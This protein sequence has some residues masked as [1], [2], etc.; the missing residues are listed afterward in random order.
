[1]VSCGLSGDELREQRIAEGAMLWNGEMC[2][3]DRHQGVQ[4]HQSHFTQDHFHGLHPGN[5]VPRTVQHHP[6]V[7]KYRLAMQGGGSDYFST[8]SIFFTYR[9]SI[10][11]DESSGLEGLFL[12]LIHI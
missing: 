8:G 12:S 5:S 4:T 10:R 6:I 7:L 11:E 1:M 3:R 9:Q 2:I